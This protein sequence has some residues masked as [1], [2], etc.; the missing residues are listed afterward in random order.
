MTV[1]TTFYLRKFYSC[2]GFNTPTHCVVT[3]GIK[4]ECNHL[5]RTTYP[6]DCVGGVDWLPF[7]ALLAAAI[8]LI[9][10]SCAP[11]KLETQELT[12]I[13]ADGTSIVVSAEVAR[14]EAERNR[15][16]MERR[17]IPDGT[18]MLFVFEN[19]QILSFW[20]KNTP[21]P[22]SIAFISS[23]G[24]IKDIFDMTPYSLAPV[25]SSG[26]ARYALEVPQGWFMRTGIQVGDRITGRVIG[27]EQLLGGL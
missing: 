26:Y 4:T 13:K 27:G 5:M 6:D 25:Q 8:A 15:G 1:Q 12:I 9:F 2:G 16:F 18:G 7:R 11:S 22:L 19:D 10:I 24:R 21:T 14:T 20:M 17:H 23:D 3:R